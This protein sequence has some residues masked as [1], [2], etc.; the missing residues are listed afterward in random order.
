MNE[1]IVTKDI[2]IRDIKKLYKEGYGQIPIIKIID[3]MATEY[4][5]LV[6]IEDKKEDYNKIR[7]KMFE[8]IKNWCEEDRLNLYGT[9]DLNKIIRDVEKGIKFRDFIEKKTGKRKYFSIDQINR[10]EKKNV[11]GTLKKLVDRY[12]SQDIGM[13]IMNFFKEMI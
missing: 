8:V 7:K 13:A 2:I 11:D 12:Y 4:A 10:F 5:K 9:I 1:E 6:V 3:N